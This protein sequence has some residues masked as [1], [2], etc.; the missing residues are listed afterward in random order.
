MFVVILIMSVLQSPIAATSARIVGD[1]GAPIQMIGRP[2][3]ENQT[4]RIQAVPVPG[5]IADEHLFGAYQSP[6]FSCSGSCEV[7]FV[8]GQA[9][10]DA[11]KLGV[12]FLL[13]DGTFSQGTITKAPAIT[14][15]NVC[16]GFDVT[17]IPV[18]AYPARVQGVLLYVAGVKFSGGSEWRLADETKTV[19]E[20]TNV[21]LKQAR[22]K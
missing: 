6:P 19:R 20:A 15:R 5:V 3:D 17:R 12:I 16:F 8:G 11:V 22:S 9:P 10:L 2:C 14:G 1:P 21:W 18:Q 4:T 7:A 13:A